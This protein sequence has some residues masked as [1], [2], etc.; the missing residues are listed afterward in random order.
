MRVIKADAR[1]YKT[2]QALI[3]GKADLVVSEMLGS[4]GCNELEPEVLEFIEKEFCH[5]KSIIIPQKYSSYIGL[6]LKLFCLI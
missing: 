6:F 1:D 5:E 4:F 3:K 2:L